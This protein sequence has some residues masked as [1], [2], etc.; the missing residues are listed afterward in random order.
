ME[1][2]MRTRKK[3]YTNPHQAAPGE[4]PTGRVC[5]VILNDRGEPTGKYCYTQ[6]K[7]DTLIERLDAAEQSRAP[8]VVQPAR[9]AAPPREAPPRVVQ[10]VRETALP[11]RAAASPREAPPRVVQPTR[12][13]ALPREP[14]PRVGRFDVGVDDDGTIISAGVGPFGPYVTDGQTTA[15]LPR[16]FDITQVTLEDAK[17]AFQLKRA[18]TPEWRAGREAPEDYHGAGGEVP[19]WGLS[20]ATRQRD[21]DQAAFAQPLRRQLE[22][23]TLAEGDVHN[24]TL[25]DA[26]RLLDRK[27]KQAST[28]VLAIFLRMFERQTASEQE[29]GDA[30]VLNSRG[31][32]AGDS[33]TATKLV[34]YLRQA[35]AVRVNEAGLLMPTQ[36]PLPYGLHEQIVE[37]LAGYPRQVVSIMNEG[38]ARTRKVVRTNPRRPAHKRRR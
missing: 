4:D 9:E 12:E 13:T 25:A 21:M 17:A 10:P 19:R 3:I 36:T 38:A 32:N 18:K 26:G 29:A 31:F 23:H 24:Y 33:K 30:R 14:K 11:R 28:S 5:I 7:A 34:S 6:K 22:M 8:R 27:D 35:G 20:F 2:M 1:F 15:S 16:D 37:L